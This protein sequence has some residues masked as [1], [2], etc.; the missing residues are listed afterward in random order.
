MFDS[1]RVYRAEFTVYMQYTQATRH[2]IF[3]LE[4]KEPHRPWSDKAVKGTF[5]NR[6]SRSICNLSRLHLLHKTVLGR[7][8]RWV[9]KTGH[10]E[11]MI[12]QYT[13]CTGLDHATFIV[14]YLA[15]RRLDNGR[16][17]IDL[18]TLI[19]DKLKVAGFAVQALTVGSK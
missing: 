4:K 14:P 18:G 16:I 10:Y 19:R 12:I 17:S 1:Q 15:V 7:L 2:K 3:Q 13:C 5:V 9:V 6:I 8:F 11:R